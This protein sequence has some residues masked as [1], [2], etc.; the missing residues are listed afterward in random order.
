MSGV[1]EVDGLKEARRAFRDAEGQ[2]RD[3]SAAHRRV[4]QAAA[5]RIRARAAT[6]TRQQAAAA[7]VIKGRGTASGADVAVTNTAAV[8]FGK[9]AFFGSLRWE[10][11]PMWVGN[12]WDISEGDG[13][14]IITEVL[15]S[16]TEFEQLSLMFLEEFAAALATAGLT[17]E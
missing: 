13:P 17:I 4:A 6:G 1:V 3:L 12:T 16:P 14:Y 11:F 10:Q 7:K 9:G 8:P 2:A 5:E 15:N